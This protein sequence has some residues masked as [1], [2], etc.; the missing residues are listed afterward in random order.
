M[1]KKG[2]RV[3]GVVGLWQHLGTVLSVC[4]GVIRTVR[5]VR[6]NPWDVERRA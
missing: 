5:H 6:D 4:E 1:S 3:I 2:A